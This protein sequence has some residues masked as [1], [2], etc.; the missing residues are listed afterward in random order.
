MSNLL[1]SR[2]ITSTNS[3]T[4]DCVERVQGSSAHEVDGYV[5]QHGHRRR[6][7]NGTRNS[8]SP[9]PNGIPATDADRGGL[10][11]VSCLPPFERASVRGREYHCT[12]LVRVSA[13]THLPIQRC[14]IA[15][16]NTISPCRTFHTYGKVTS[17]PTCPRSFLRFRTGIYPHTNSTESNLTKE[18]RSYRRA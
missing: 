11:S 3:P 8:N 6:H 1:K 2:S 16:L 18:V 9:V 7:E 15:V 14:F 13:K 12:V 5:H 17:S 4:C 10:L